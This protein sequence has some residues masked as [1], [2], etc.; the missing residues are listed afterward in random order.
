MPRDDDLVVDEELLT[1]DD[2]LVEDEVPLAD[3]DE[4]P[5]EVERLCEDV[6]VPLDPEERLSCEYESTGDANKASDTA[7]TRAMLKML[8]ITIKF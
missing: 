1:E 5:E 3:E 2:D 4:L 6:V 8:F 7:D